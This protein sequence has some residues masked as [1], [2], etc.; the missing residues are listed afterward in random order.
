MKKILIVE[1]E[2]AILR[3][4]EDWISYSQEKY[5]VVS[6]RDG[7]EA[8]KKLSENSIDL[9]LLDLVMP[10]MDGFTFLETLKN[11]AIHTKVV[12]LTNLGEQQ[13][14]ERALR[15]GAAHYFVKN[16]TKLTTVFE[17]IKQLLD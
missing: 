3:A 8:L 7:E 4:L 2:R 5:E 12:I 14:K 17:A 16:E 11:N 6:A 9:I 10:T 1:D 13:D 15:L